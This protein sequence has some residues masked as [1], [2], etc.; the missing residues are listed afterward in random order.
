MHR[1]THRLLGSTRTVDGLE[2]RMRVQAAHSG[3]GV[4]VAFRW[5]ATDRGLLLATEVVPFGVWDCTWPR[6]GV[7]IDLPAALAEHP[8]A[9]HGTG[10]GESYPDSRTAVRVGRFASTVDGLAVAY[11]RPQETGHRPELRSLVVGDGSATPLTV[12]TVPDASGHRAGFQLSRWTPQEMTDVGH[13][14]E[15]PRPRRAAPAPR[16]RPARPRIPR[17]RPRRAPAP[18]ALAVAAHVG[19][20]AGVRQ[21]AAPSSRRGSA[22]G[23]CTSRRRVDS[24]PTSRTR[25]DRATTCWARALP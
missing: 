20:A 1:L 9:W 21:R 13:P 15:P 18:R 7:R 24:S 5:T 22:T 16:P 12:T 3:A 14:H 10:P 17:V 4:D 2:T 8:V 6:V 11:A 19:G 25:P 23:R